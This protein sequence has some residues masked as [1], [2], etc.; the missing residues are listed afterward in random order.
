M[1]ATFFLEEH[2][3]DGAGVEG[4]VEVDEVHARVRHV[5][6]QD[7]EVVAEVELILFV[8]FTESITQGG[9]VAHAAGVFGLSGSAGLR[10]QPCRKDESPQAQADVLAAVTGRVD[11]CL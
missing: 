6:A 7:F 1:V 10:D 2:V 9:R 5:F 4:R 3:V 11:G 8:H